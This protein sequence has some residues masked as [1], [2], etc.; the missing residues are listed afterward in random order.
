MIETSASRSLEPNPADPSLQDV[1]QI[2]MK[3][4]STK[5]ERKIMATEL[6]SRG[7]KAIVRKRGKDYMKKIGRIGAKKRWNKK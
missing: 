4:E 5:T 6:G 7:G 1:T 3:K 2:R